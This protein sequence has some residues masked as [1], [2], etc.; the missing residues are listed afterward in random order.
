[1]IA[2]GGLGNPW[3]FEELPGAREEPPTPS[4]MI[5]ELRWVVD[6]AGEHWGTERAA[7]KCAS[8]I[9]GTSSGSDLRGS[10]QD[11]FQRTRIS[12]EVARACS[13][14]RATRSTA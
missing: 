6:R 13:T 12:S 10:E 4:E 2:R 8:S 1:M 9:P 14:Q 7:R 11:A 3:L 5:D